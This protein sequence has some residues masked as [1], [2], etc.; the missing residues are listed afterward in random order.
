MSFANLSRCLIP[1]VGGESRERGENMGCERISG[2]IDDT[3]GTAG[4]DKKRRRWK[5]RSKDE[6]GIDTKDVP[7]LPKK[8]ADFVDGAEQKI[9]HK[10][11]GGLQ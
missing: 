1:C 3:D 10:L 7:N 11:C 5:G 4:V 2:W 9:Q 6:G 8:T